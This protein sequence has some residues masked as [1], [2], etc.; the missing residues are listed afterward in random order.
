MIFSPFFLPKCSCIIFKGGEGGSVGNDFSRF[1]GLRKISL[2][3]KLVSLRFVLQPWKREAQYRTWYMLCK[4]IVCL[5]ASF[6]LL[7]NIHVLIINDCWFV[8]CCCF[9]L[10]SPMVPLCFCGLFVNFMDNRLHWLFLVSQC[11]Q[12][13]KSHGCSMGERW[14]CCSDPRHPN[15]CRRPG[16]QGR[17]CRQN[18]LTAPSLFSV[19]SSLPSPLLA[20]LSSLP[21]LCPSLLFPHSL[22]FPFPKLR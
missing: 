1:T 14:W 2:V 20:T 16:G 21:S 22:S 13:P 15:L 17:T 19:F 5:V 6:F 3:S 9:F 12:L 18:P 4:V 7:S 11:Q 8:C 10:R